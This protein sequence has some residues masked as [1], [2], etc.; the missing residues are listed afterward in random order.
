MTSIQ[1]LRTV[2]TD[3]TK[4]VW[5]VYHFSRDQLVQQIYNFDMKAMILNPYMLDIATASECYFAVQ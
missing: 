2:K 3:H 5:S 1:Q 4:N